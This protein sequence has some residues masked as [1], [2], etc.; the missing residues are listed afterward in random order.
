[1]G[2]LERPAICYPGPAP[3]QVRT[4]PLALSAPHRSTKCAPHRSTAA[5][6]WQTAPL[7]C[8]EWLLYSSSNANNAVHTRSFASNFRWPAVPVLQCWLAGTK[9]SLTVLDSLTGRW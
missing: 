4:T 3:L 8:V 9:G 5:P 7:H 2:A 6:G 1:M